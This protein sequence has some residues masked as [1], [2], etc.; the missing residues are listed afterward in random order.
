MEKQLNEAV[1]KEKWIIEGY[2][3]PSANIR[4]EN[5]DTIIY[6]DYSGL[7]VVIGGLQR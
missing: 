4:L 6:L 2:I 3:H 5:A 1:K 7:Q